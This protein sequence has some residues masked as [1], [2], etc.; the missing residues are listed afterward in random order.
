M[1][2]RYGVTSFYDG[3]RGKPPT[4]DFK[5]FQQL[6]YSIGQEIHSRVSIIEKDGVAHNYYYALFTGE[7]K[8]GLVCNAHYPLVAFVKNFEGPCFGNVLVSAEHTSIPGV[9]SA[10][11]YFEYLPGGTLE[12]ELI[13]EM[14]QDLGVSE[15]QQIK[16]W[17]SKSV[18]EVV[19]NYYD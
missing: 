11:D 6:C 1:K 19:F 8:R 18:S 15:L 14:Y 9:V 13:Q 12:A 16:E 17:G 4:V 5:L 10:T 3:S 7:P 2:L